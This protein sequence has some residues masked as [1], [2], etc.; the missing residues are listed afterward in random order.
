MAEGLASI[1]GNGIDSRN[2]V[3]GRVLI[4]ANPEASIATIG[5]AGKTGKARSRHLTKVVDEIVER[6]EGGEVV[7][8][9]G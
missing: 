7:V 9:V 1:P 2:E 8:G 4:L 5:K 6:V 3:G